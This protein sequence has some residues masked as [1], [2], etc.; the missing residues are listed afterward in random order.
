MTCS[1]LIRACIALW[2]AAV[3]PC[4]AK[5]LL[6]VPAQAERVAHMIG[7]SPLVRNALKSH[8]DSQQAE[9]LLALSPRE[10][11]W[12]VIQ[13]NHLAT[14]VATDPSIKQAGHT[15]AFLA[16]INCLRTI[17]SQRDASSVSHGPRDT[18][19]DLLGIDHTNEVK[20]ITVRPPTPGRSFTI[21]PFQ[22]IK[23]DPP[24]KIPFNI[25]KGRVKFKDVDHIK[26]ADIS[27]GAAA[28]TKGA[29]VGCTILSSCRSRVGKALLRS[30]SGAQSAGIS[31]NIQDNCTPIRF[32]PRSS[33]AT[34]S[35]IVRSLDQGES[36]TC[37]S[38]TTRTG[39]TVN[40]SIQLHGPEGDT[41]FTI[42]GLVDNQHEY[43]FKTEAK[44]FNILV[45]ST[46]ARQP[47][48]PFTLEVSVK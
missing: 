33:S 17:T 13:T 31:A 35:G 27:K 11:G 15:D 45:Y 40:I 48:R 9:P 20:P 8:L 44:T 43:T 30:T 7:V 3:A 18:S 6:K 32:A 34:V 24:I 5:P 25:W 10:L 22:G 41:A 36:S 46:L 23:I 42:P 14:I 26:W 19:F 1:K 28:V 12:K 2:L 4:N 21:D 47:P 16:S 29:G 37:Y 38:L 39:Q